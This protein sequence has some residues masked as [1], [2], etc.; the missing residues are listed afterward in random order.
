MVA[1]VLSAMRRPSFNQIRILTWPVSC[2]V[3]SGLIVTKLLLSPA[4]AEKGCMIGASTL[5]EIFCSYV[6]VC[7]RIHCKICLY[8]LNGRMSAVDAHARNHIGLACKYYA[9]PV[10]LQMQL[11]STWLCHLSCYGEG[12]VVREENGRTRKDEAK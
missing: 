10:Q 8:V 11:H 5:N 9:V 1:T 4:V 6:A 3:S 7:T 2:F 12:L